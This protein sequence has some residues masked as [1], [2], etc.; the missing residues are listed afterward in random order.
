MTPSLGALLPIV[1]RRRPAMPWGERGAQTS[2]STA[3]ATL[4]VGFNLV[5]DRGTPF[6]LR[7]GGRARIHLCCP[8]AVVPGLPARTRRAPEADARAAPRLALDRAVFVFC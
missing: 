3:A 1:Q 4:Y 5:W 6:G 8:Y 2:R 7:S